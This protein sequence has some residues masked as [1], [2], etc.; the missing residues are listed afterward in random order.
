MDY[1]VSFIENQLPVILIIT[2]GLYTLPD[3]QYIEQSLKRHHGEN[4]FFKIIKTSELQSLDDSYKTVNGL[5]LFR[6]SVLP[7]LNY[8]YLSSLT[9][10]M[11]TITDEM[12]SIFSNPFLTF[13]RLDR[14]T[15]L[16]TKPHT[17]FEKCNNLEVLQL[18][19]STVNSG[20]LVLPR[21]LKT[22]EISGKIKLHIMEVYASECIQLEHIKF[23]EPPRG[24]DC[25]IDLK[26]PNVACLRT[27]KTTRPVDIRDFET[28]IGAL[29]NLKKLT[30]CWG[31]IKCYSTILNPYYTSTYGK[32]TASKAYSLDLSLFKCLEKISF[33]NPKPKKNL[34]VTLPQGRHS[35]DIKAI[36]EDSNLS[37]VSQVSFE[38]ETPITID[39]SYF[40]DLSVSCPI[41]K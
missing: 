41:S 19:S 4:L 33:F 29:L 28:S 7:T 13:I 3:F 10:N 11:V 31:F 37:R 17:I 23:D 34:V 21:Y 6:L 39:L 30:I 36:R 2:K 25:L 18:V 8:T 24:Y 15:I 40:I 27:F 1:Q 9:L 20:H 16:T 26:L 12:S 5:Y 14:C 35:I 38:N 22:L 32:K